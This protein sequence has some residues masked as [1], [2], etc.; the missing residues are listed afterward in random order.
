MKLL[1]R[2]LIYAAILIALLIIAFLGY[3]SLAL[4]SVGEP[5]DI[6]IEITPARLERGE[7][8][9]HHV[10][11]C[12]DCHTTRDW[13]TFSAPPKIEMLASGNFDEFVEEMGF[14]GNYY[15]SNLTPANLA[16]WTDGEILRAITTGVNKDGRALFP[17]MPYLNYGKMDREDIY[18]IIAYMRTLKPIE[19]ETPESV[20]KF[21]LNFI[22][23]TIPK[24]AE[25]SKIP[26]KSNSVE[27]GR[28]M[29]M[30]SACGDCHTPAEKGEP[31]P[32]MDFAGGFKFIVPTGGE[33]N[34]ANITPDKSTG[35]GSW[36]KEQFILR[37]KLYADS[38]YVPHK[39]A[40]NQFNTWMPWTAYSKM[41]EEDLGAIYDYLMSL[42]PVRNS[43]VK[44]EIK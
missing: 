1:L 9:F 19:S 26:D 24:P 43:V 31:I 15:A 40:E 18:S 30:A 28:Y 13:T 6:T 29:T 35:I 3:F 16:E 41:D 14:P 25:F 23:K 4:P 44:F 10:T 12:G 7:Y 27:Y 20:P 42:E 33:V 22:I 2:I 17:V 37:F 34:S 32:G 38:N 21:P 39:V 8:L 11:M 36:T 5:E